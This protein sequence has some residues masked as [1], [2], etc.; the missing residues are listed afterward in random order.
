MVTSFVFF[1]ALIIAFASRKKVV[2]WGRILFGFGA[3]FVGLQLMGDQLIKLQDLAFFEQF[4][5]TMSRNP[6]LALIG[7]TI[8]TAI[9]NSSVYMYL[10]LYKKVKI[11]VMVVWT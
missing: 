11:M 3:I 1:G 8:A 7:G 4:M 6:W 5:E 9:I 10:G 2:E